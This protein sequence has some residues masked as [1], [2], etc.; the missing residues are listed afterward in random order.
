M[1]PQILLSRGE[2][3]H[4]QQKM[5]QDRRAPLGAQL[6][7]GTCLGMFIELRL[8]WKVLREPDKVRSSTLAN[9]FSL[10][11]SCLLFSEKSEAMV[12]PNPHLGYPSFVRSSR[13]QIK[14]GTHGVCSVPGYAQYQD[15]LSTRV[16]PLPG[17]AQCQGVL[18]TRVCPLPWYAQWQDMYKEMMK[19]MIGVVRPQQTNICV[20]HISL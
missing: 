13:V 18:N 17:Y 16:C 7:F 1:K 11:V 4:R 8:F 5:C 14:C 9:G 19:K 15:K 10:T 6:F 12:V 3:V 20:H 2:S